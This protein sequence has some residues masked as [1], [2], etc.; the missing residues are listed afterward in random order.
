MRTEL[1]I[2][3]YIFYLLTL[4]F[5]LC[6]FIY[7]LSSCEKDTDG[8]ANSNNTSD[9]DTDEMITVNFTME[10]IPVLLNQS[11]PVPQ[12]EVYSPLSV[13]IDGVFLSQPLKEL[14][15]EDTSII[16]SPP[17]G[18]LYIRATL[19]ENTNPVSLRAMTLDAGTKIRIIAY[20]ISSGDTTIVAF[21]DYEIAGGGNSLLPVSPPISLPSGSYKF[22][23]Y[24]YNEN[25]ALPSYADITSAIA[26]KDLLWGESDANVSPGSTTVHIQME[27][28]FSSIILHAEVN[29]LQGNIIYGIDV[30][31]F[32]HSFPSLVVRSKN[33][34]PS[35]TNS[36]IDFEWPSGAG[37]ANIWN[38]I[39]HTVYTNGEPPTL[40]IDSVTI[41][42]DTYYGPFPVAYTTALEPGKEYTLNVRFIRCTEL[43]GVSL[44]S[45]PAS[46]GNMLTGQTLYL[47]AT[48]N[49]SDATDVEY[50]W[51]YFNGSTWVT[52]SITTTPNFNA[53]ILQGNNQF[54][55]LA[56]NMCSN[57]QTSNTIAM[58]GI[59]PVGGS[60]SRITWDDVN[61]RY[62][63]T[64]DPR[65]AGLYFRFG[66]VVGLF[67]GAGRHTQDLS[68]G[69]NTSA[70][71]AANHVTINVSTTTINVINDL[72]Y[73]NSLTDIDAAYHTPVHVK[74]GLGDP[75]RLV[76]LDLNNIKNKTASQ[77]QQ[78]EIDNGLW[79]LPTGLEHRQF[80]GYTTNQTGNPG[81]WWWAYNQNP[82]NFTLGIAGGEFPERNH[83][84]GGA[85]K[86][87]PA[88]GDRTNAGVAGRQLSRS[89]FLTSTSV[90]G[91]TS[92]EGF[93]LE[94]NQI[95][96]TSASKEWIWPV[97]CVPQ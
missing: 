66:S 3:R 60:A 78:Y 20:T 70:F 22:V 90:S 63:L 88:V 38:S 95:L 36:L 82:L 69:T 54:R 85:G 55:V 92:Y 74:A 49:P 62:V 21:A 37:Y 13:E 91:G 97:R 77:L 47:T 94:A 89:F 67:S 17:Q 50:E 58:N 83:V 24:S 6:G 18:D 10:S 80:S 68:Q 51:Q 59:T 52:M 87:L 43:T 9:L 44:A 57:T 53:T 14:I 31:R 56:S 39:Y 28:L 79:R 15:V 84:N 48:L 41:N 23:A 11:A 65:D 8:S 40:T 29:P 61:Q 5:I 35:P 76:G 64:T 81:V 1:S 27:H 96:I 75:C 4:L 71:N 12:M 34:I 32:E 42:T 73:V 93:L 86:F 72:P 2:K 33:L 16:I 19:T 7:L 30:A 26:S 25:A 45:N 46:G